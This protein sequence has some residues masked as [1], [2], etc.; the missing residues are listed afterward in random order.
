MKTELDAARRAGLQEHRRNVGEWVTRWPVLD[1]L[2]SG[3]IKLEQNWLPDMKINYNFSRWRGSTAASTATGRSRRR[4]PARRPS[5]CIRRFRDEQRDLI[6]AAGD[7][8]G[9]AAKTPRATSRARALVLRVYGLRSR[10][11]GIINEARRDGSVVLPRVA[12][13]AGRAANGR[14]DS[15]RSAASRSARRTLPEHYLL[16]LVDWGKPVTVDVRRGLDQPFTR[17]RGSICLSDTQPASQKDVGCTICHDGQGSGTDLQVGFAHAE[18]RRQQDEWARRARLVRQPP[19]DLPDDAGAVH[20]E[21]LPEVPPQKVE[22]GAER[23]VPRAAG[24]EAGRRLDAG[25][26]VRLLRLPRDQR[27]RRPDGDGRPRPAAR[28]ALSRGRRADSARR[29][30]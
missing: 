14:R 3:N 11:S 4:R 28:A 16:E 18:R 24:A 25:R 17:T 8:R 20:R 22:L 12:G 9:A 23:A 30:A 27:L 10:E 26:G 2:Y 29:E 5:R 7:A 1:A 15:K 21:Q 13:R 19:L 6:V